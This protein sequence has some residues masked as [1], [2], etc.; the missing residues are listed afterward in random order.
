MSR[1]NAPA[2]G[3]LTTETRAVLDGIGAQFGFVP[4]MFQTLAANPTV[5]EVVT[6]LQSKLAR[7]LDAKTRH[8]IAL[9]VSESNGCDYCLAMHSYV[10]LQLGGMSQEDIRLARSG[11]SIDPRRSAVAHFVQQV[12]DTRGHVSDADLAAVRGAGYTDAQILAIVTVTVQFLLTNFL[13][14]VNKTEVDVPAIDT[15]AAA[16]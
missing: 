12:V 5:L 15:S 2:T 16:P 8:T 9:A 11:S 4:S 3:D 10:S 6:S 7:V 1:L 13:N 14:N